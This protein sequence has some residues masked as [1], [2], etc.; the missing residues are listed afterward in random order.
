MTELLNFL[1][2]S[3]LSQLLGAAGS[4]L[5]LLPPAADQIRR[6][7]MRRWRSSA[8]GAPQALKSGA[9]TALDTIETDQSGW[10]A[11]ESFSMAV[12]G[13]LLMLSFWH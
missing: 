13:A 5:L 12:G 4:F 9:R 7:R 6:L 2:L 8:S 3:S 10:K 11:W 1:G